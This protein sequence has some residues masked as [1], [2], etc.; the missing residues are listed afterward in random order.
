MTNP[1]YWDTP[2][3]SSCTTGTNPEHQKPPCWSYRLP[4]AAPSSPDAKHSRVRVS[5]VFHRVSRDSSG[6]SCHRASACKR[7]Y[8]CTVRPPPQSCRRHDSDKPSAH[9]AF[10]ISFRTA[11][12][13]SIG[14]GSIMIFG[15]IRPMGSKTFFTCLKAS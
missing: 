9:S 1:H 5:C 11:G 6:T 7:L 15:F 4:R 13:W 14:F 2:P 8:R 10:Y 3:C 12:H